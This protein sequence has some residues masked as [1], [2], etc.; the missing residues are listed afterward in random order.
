MLGDCQRDGSSACEPANS[1]CGGVQ[2]RLHRTSSLGEY[3]KI[4]AWGSPVVWKRFTSRTVV[5]R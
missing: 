4:E 1:T 5:A 3:S 2:I